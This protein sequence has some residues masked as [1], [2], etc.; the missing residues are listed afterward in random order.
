L[1][2][3]LREGL[4]RVYILVAVFPFLVCGYGEC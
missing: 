1:I 4:V 2:W 3:E